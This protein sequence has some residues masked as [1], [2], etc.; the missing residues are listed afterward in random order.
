MRSFCLSTLLHLGIILIIVVPLWSQ[1]FSI[2]KTNYIRAYAVTKITTT[3]MHHTTSKKTAAVTKPKKENQH[4]ATQSKHG[5]YSALLRSLHDQI[6]QAIDS[7]NSFNGLNEN[8]TAEIEFSITATGEIQNIK[9]IKSTGLAVVDKMIVAAV[10]N[11]QAIPRQLLL[12]KTNTFA[13]RI[14]LGG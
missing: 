6:Q 2:S 9:L 14:Y 7:Q 1:H 11:I 3:T 13:I 12:S 8:Q 5:K 10:K 4:V